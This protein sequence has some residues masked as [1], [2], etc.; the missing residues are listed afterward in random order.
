MFGRKKKKRRSHDDMEAGRGEPSAGR[1]LEM[2]PLFD[3]SGLGRGV[4]ARGRRKRPRIG[5]RRLFGHGEGH[6]LGRGRGKYSRALGDYALVG[7]ESDST[8]DDDFK[9]E[10]PPSERSDDPFVL[11]GFN[12]AVS[13]DGKSIFETP[14][15]MIHH[16][17]TREEK[18]NID[19][20]IDSPPAYFSDEDFPESTRARVHRRSTS[21]SSSS[22]VSGYSDYENDWTEFEVSS[23]SGT[24]SHSHSGSQ[25]GDELHNRPFRLVCSH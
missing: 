14:H 4:S 25:G 18:L 21:S 3:H 15:P 16:D 5:D 9:H 2:Q 8:S 11:R 23:D 13:E 7:E 17:S 24:S 19:A 6:F 12:S 1:W 20:S 10:S 22:S